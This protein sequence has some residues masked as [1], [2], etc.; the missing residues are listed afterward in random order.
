MNYGSHIRLSDADLDGLYEPFDV[1]H[2]DF[3]T[4]TGPELSGE[5][6]PFD[7]IDFGYLYSIAYDWMIPLVD[8]YYRAEIVNPDQLPKSGPAIVACNHSGNAFPHDAMVLDSLIWRHFG[9][10]PEHK[11]RSV[12]SPK[13]AKAWWMRPFGLDNWWRRAGGIDMTFDNYEHLLKNGERV[14]YYP[15][16]VPGIGKG[17]IRRYQLQHFYSSFVV[18]A[19]KHHVPV[20]PIVCV[21]A[22]FVNPGNITFPWLDKVFDKLFG[23]PFFPV[24]AVLLA[25]V[26]PFF[27]YFGFPCKMKF[28]V[29]EAIDVRGLFRQHGFDPDK[30]N[31]ESAQHIAEKIRQRVQSQLNL[32]VERYGKDPYEWA[33]WWKKMKISPQNW[34]RSSAF[35]WPYTFIQHDRDLN[36]KPAKNKLHRFLRDWDILAFYIPFGWI[37]LALIRMFSMPPKGYRGLSKKQRIEKDGGYLWRLEKRPLATTPQSRKELAK[38]WIGNK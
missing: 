7:P 31:R 24:P 35:G 11:F 15:E 20:Y 6:Q 33:D 29:G 30:I 18:L 32:A 34:F 21:N 5:G 14:I 16:G 13:L 23:L 2:P 38:P 1:M 3:E 4:A 17:F 26:F 9:L 28:E 37:M 27:F 25:M 22:E 10:K 12:F 36:R 8:H 19:A